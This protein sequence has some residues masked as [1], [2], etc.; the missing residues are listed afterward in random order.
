MGYCI[1][2]AYP[3]RGG[4]RNQ[5][6]LNGIAAQVFADLQGRNLPRLA[7]KLI[8]KWTYTDLPCPSISTENPELNAV[9]I[10]HNDVTDT[11]FMMFRRSIDAP[12]LSYQGFFPFGTDINDIPLI[13]LYC[14]LYLTL[15]WDRTYRNE[16]SMRAIL[17]KYPDVDIQSC[18]NSRDFQRFG[19][20]VL[21][22]DPEVFR[23]PFNI[24]TQDDY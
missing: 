13:S 16:W 2:T 10:D 17:D 8:N 20:E 9:F 18:T 15:E 1:P 24:F 11:V 7:A 22:Y 5:E 12:S 4:K 23:P 3:P 21:G 19:F 14:G 6:F